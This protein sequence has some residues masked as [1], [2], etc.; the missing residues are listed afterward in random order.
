M[1]QSTVQTDF[2]D[3][4]GSGVVQTTFIS[5]SGCTDGLILRAFSAEGFN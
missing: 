4:S 2:A 3:S 5:V 1:V